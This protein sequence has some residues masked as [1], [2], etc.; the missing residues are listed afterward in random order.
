MAVTSITGLGTGL[1]INDIVK[2][3][4]DAEKAPKQTQITTQQTITNT[5]LSALGTLKSAMEAFQ[6]SLS[7]LNTA[8]S[9]AGLSAKSSNESTLKVTSDSSAVGGTYQVSVNSLATSSKVA[10]AAIDDGANTKFSKGVITISQNGNSYPVNIDDGASLKDVRD[11]INTRYSSAGISANILTDADGKTRLVLGSTKTGAG[12][13]ITVT[14]KNSNTALPGNASL[15]VFE[16]KENAQLS[17]DGSGYVNDKPAQDAI[18][19]IDGM[20][21]K[22]SSNTVTSVNG[23]S[24]KLTAVGDSNVTVNTNTDGLKNSIQSFVMAYNT[25]LSATNALT[26]VSATTSDS[27]AT[28]NASALTGDSTIRTMLNSVRKELVSSS[29]GGGTI[30][31]LSQL[32]VNTQRDGTL[33]IND[34][35]LS[36]ALAENSASVAGFFTGDNGLLSR[37]SKVVDGYTKSDGVLADREKS[38]NSKLVDLKDQQSAL[39]R[40]ITK[41]QTDL[42]S[43][44]NAMDTLVAQLNATSNSVL[45][46]LNALNKSKND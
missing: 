36:K 16:I 29:A 3:V 11:A 22:S 4:V 39:D 5:T 14:A 1:N 13:D 21:I 25:L 23:L 44:Y 18:L 34:T 7:S 19:S 26:K 46:T 43:K 31:L 20:A 33:E 17:I 2:A 24:M 35:K 9:F 37:M 15:A 10:T 8:T 6:N 27:G 38:L 40:R 41:V 28:V 32:G 45:T 30:K 42:Y 12:S